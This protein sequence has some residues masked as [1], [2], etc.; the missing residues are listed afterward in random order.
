MQQPTPASNLASDKADL[1]KLW[2][3]TARKVVPATSFENESNIE[4]IVGESR[5]NRNGLN[6]LP[7]FRMFK[8]RLETLAEGR[9]HELFKSFL[10]GGRRD[11]KGF[12]V[13]RH[14]LVDDL[15]RLLLRDGFDVNSLEIFRLQFGTKLEQGYFHLPEPKAVTF[16][17]G[18][19]VVACIVH[20][21][22]LLFP[23]DADNVDLDLI[24]PLLREDCICVLLAPRCLL[25]TVAL[26]VR[27]VNNFVFIVALVL[28]DEFG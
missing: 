27:D 18:V 25:N 22:S 16:S 11:L 3:P 26:H 24:A 23:I 2:Q 6:V 19:V 9:R 12:A 20:R 21:D 4:I 15:Y 5:A 28:R 7:N 13:L 8:Q 1:S 10:V 14:G 17:L